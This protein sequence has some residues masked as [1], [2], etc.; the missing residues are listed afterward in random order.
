M[1]YIAMSTTLIVAVICSDGVFVRSDKRNTIKHRNGPTEYH[2]DL[3]K[4]FIATNRKIVIYNHGINR[5][6]G[7]PWREHAAALAGQLQQSQPTNL[8]AVLDLAANLLDPAVVAELGRNKLDGFCAFVVI[9]KLPDG[10]Y[11]AGEVSWKRGA[12]AQ[13]KPLGRFI[14][15]GS[16]VRYL[17]PTAQQKRNEHWSE[18]TMD[19]A[20]AEVAELFD[21]AVQAQEAAQGQE[22]S[23]ACDDLAV[24]P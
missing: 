7:I 11:H 20:R 15:S 23:P 22:F 4:V 2:D 13:K 6:N 3:N 10:R 8:T 18:L 19:A 17:Q 21:A 5:I 12:T 1:L 14:R 16:G 24:T 9:V